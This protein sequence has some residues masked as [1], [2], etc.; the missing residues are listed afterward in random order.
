MNEYIMKEMSIITS[1]NIIRIKIIT[2]NVFFELKNCYF[3]S[4]YF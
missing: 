4:L 3:L 2:N 1:K